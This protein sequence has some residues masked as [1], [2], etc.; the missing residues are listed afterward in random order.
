M[1]SWLRLT[2][3]FQ[4]I[5]LALLV[6]A[7]GVWTSSFAT[8]SDRRSGLLILAIILAYFAFRK[9]LLWRF[10]NRLMITFFLFGVVPLFLIYW[11]LELS[12]VLVLSQIA[13]ERVRHDL[14]AR[15]ERVHDVAQDMMLVGSHNAAPVLSEGIRRR[16]PRL[17]AIV[18][19]KG[20]TVLL[21]PGH[22]AFSTAPAWMAANFQ[23]LFESEG[24]Y[25][26]GANTGDEQANA[27]VFTYLPLDDETLATLTPETAAVTGIV[28]VK[29]NPNVDVDA[30]GNYVAVD[31]NGVR[32]RIASP[33]LPPPKNI[34]DVTIPALLP[35][36]AQTASGKTI[37]IMFPIVSRPSQLMAGV[38][39]GRIGAIIVPV[40]LFVG[41]LFLAVEIVAL[42][43][44]AMLTRSIT[45]SV[46]DLYQGT[47]LVAAGDFSHDIPVSGQHQL[48]DLAAS[49]NGMTK[50]I[51]HYIGEVRKKEKLESELEIA[52]QVQARLFPRT[53]PELETLEMAGVCLPGRIVS[54]DYYDFINLDDRH[55]A[56][57]L[58]DVSGKGVSAALLMA[59]IQSSL[60]SQLKFHEA[61]P[62]ASLSTAT[63]MERISRQLY[64]S[65]P[66][67]KYATFFCSFYDDETGVLRYTNCG[68]LKPMVVRAGK[69]S[70]LEGSDLVAG[71]LPKISCSQREF[72]IGKGDL[73]AIFSDG[74][75]EAEN[76]AE[77]E[78][79][80]ARL[81]ELLARHSVEPLEKIVETVIEAVRVW[82]HD[83]DGRDDITLVL[84]RRR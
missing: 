32:R 71:L 36:N 12:A 25:Y 27:K 64:E 84:L 60:H 11:L 69:V 83:P 73:L 23:G 51:R 33:R 16:E 35:W 2:T 18:S 58:G 14:E 68:H 5:A 29:R 42:I 8:G 41:G 67:E 43:S 4:R 1:T 70:T 47:L 7:V 63:L 22:G 79:S 3:W 13:A 54:G 44:S 20:E 28:D 48:S 46:H 10:R 52:R 62:N 24:H 61:A 65:T 15:I 40:L 39:T 59:S 75:P 9:Q 21:P 78:F 82:T 37:E 80:E 17:A 57:V 74:I 66:A 38:N 49:F 76:A 81:A 55:T 34:W 53:V 26:L 31:E 6:A 50:Q 45:R 77:D 30:S 19:N 72:A 56:I